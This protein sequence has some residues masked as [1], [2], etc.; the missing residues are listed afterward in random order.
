MYAPIEDASQR[1]TVAD[2]PLEASGRAGFVQPKLLKMKGNA[3]VPRHT[4]DGVEL[5]L[6]LDGGFHDD[7]GTFLR[8]DLAV[9]DA[10]IRHTPIAD[11]EGC[12]CLSLTL[13]SLKLTGPVGWLLHR[14]GKF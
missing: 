1:L 5:A 11:P 4:H 9:G 2:V 3:K 6:V 14:M 13:G 10:S 7:M 12:L 8:G